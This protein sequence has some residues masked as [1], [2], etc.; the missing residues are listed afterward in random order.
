MVLTSVLRIRAGDTRLIK[1]SPTLKEPPCYM[2][3]IRRRDTKPLCSKME[4]CK[5]NEIVAERFKASSRRINQ[6]WVDAVVSAQ[7][8]YRTYQE[9]HPAST[10]ETAL[11]C[12]GETGQTRT[13]TVV[14]NAL[15]GDEAAGLD[16]GEKCSVRLLRKRSSQAFIRLLRIRSRILLTSLTFV[17][18]DEQRR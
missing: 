7:T 13:I 8:G 14:I 18:I 4:R 3:S 6:R 1:K 15:S 2:E 16:G 17:L 9:E 5:E 10:M 12:R 11:L